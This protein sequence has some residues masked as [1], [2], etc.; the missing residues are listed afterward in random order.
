MS[1]LTRGTFAALLSLTPIVAGCGAKEFAPVE[2][3]PTRL[4]RA[5]AMIYLV[6][7]AGLATADDPIIR[8]L[9]DDVSKVAPGVQTLVVYLGDNVYPRGLHPDTH[10]DHAREAAYLDAQAS[11]VA[12]TQGRAIFLPGNH[13]WGYSDERGFQQINRQAAYIDS[14][15]GAGVPVE[16]LPPVGCPGPTAIRAGDRV[17]LLLL[18]TDLWL[19]DDRPLASC[20]NTSTDAAL[21][22]LDRLLEENAEGEGRHVLVLGHHPLDSRGPHAGY[23][24]FRDQLFPGTRLWKPLFIPIPFIYP[25][26][27]NMGVTSQDLSS[28]RYEAFV[29]AFAAVFLGFDEDPL[30]YGGGH[31][32]ALTVL[33]GGEY[34]VTWQLISGAGSKLVPVS[35]DDALFSAG[36]QQGEHGYMRVAFFEDGRVL[37]TVVTDGTREC[38]GDVDLCFGQG[39]VRYWRWLVE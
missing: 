13:D 23:Y 9:R 16:F 10:P 12:G 36:Q 18:E 19:R 24:T 32:H 5:D 17:L 8:Q 7:D 35:D 15:A 28:S 1:E 20:A 33:D 30:A 21:V 14:L 22:E 6:G 39:T 37:L 38:P 2:Q 34:G 29:D 4:P 26:V 27:R 3:V 11:V 31:S 25:I